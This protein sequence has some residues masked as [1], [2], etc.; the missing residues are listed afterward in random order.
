M[1]GEGSKVTGLLSDPEPSVAA[2]EEETPRHSPD[3]DRIGATVMGGVHSRSPG[4]ALGRTVGLKPVP[5]KAPLQVGDA[6]TGLPCNPGR[7]SPAV[8]WR[9]VFIFFSKSFS[10][11]GV[12]H[13]SDLS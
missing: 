2:G 3:A 13:S 12:S 8:S 11:E 6:D 10:G 7:W 4:R 1:P 5:G 9:G